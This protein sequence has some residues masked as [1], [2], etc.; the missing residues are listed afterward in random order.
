MLSQV[1]LIKSI[2]LSH[3]L[4]NIMGCFN[5]QYYGLMAEILCTMISKLV[6]TAG[7]QMDIMI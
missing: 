4:E 3:Y 6:K 2:L 5:N 1:N 7:Y